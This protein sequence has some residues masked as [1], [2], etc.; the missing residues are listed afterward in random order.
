MPVLFALELVWSDAK[1]VP[2]GEELD[3]FEEGLAALLEEA[4]EPNGDVGFL[5]AFEQ[6]WKGKKALGHGRK[7]EEIVAPM[8][9]EGALS[10][11]VACGKEFPARGSPNREG[12]GSEQVIDTRGSPP[13]PCGHQ[14]VGI[15]NLFGMSKIEFSCQVWPIV[16]PDVSNKTR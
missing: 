6:A 16:E 1:E 8:V 11:V 4:G 9:E 3:P 5:K 14:E 15:G 12:E 2:G 10:G 7:G 13:E